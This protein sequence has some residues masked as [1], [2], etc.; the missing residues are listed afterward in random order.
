MIVKYSEVLPWWINNQEDKPNQSAFNEWIQLNMQQE[1][2]KLNMQGDYS[3]IT[4]LAKNPN[5]KY[6]SVEVN[7]KTYYYYVEN[8]NL[9]ATLTYTFNLN[10][11]TWSTYFMKVFFSINP[12]SEVFIKRCHNLTCDEKELTKTQEDSILDNIKPV[13]G[14]IDSWGES[15][16]KKISVGQE[17]YVF[18]KRDD[19][20]YKGVNESYPSLNVVALYQHPN[21]VNS[22]LVFPLPKINKGFNFKVYDKKTLTITSYGNWS[23]CYFDIN[24]NQTF[25]NNFIGVYTIPNWLIASEIYYELN[26]NGGKIIGSSIPHKANKYDEFPLYFKINNYINLNNKNELLSPKIIDYIPLFYGKD[27]IYSTDFN[28]VRFTN[29]QSMNPIYIDYNGSFIAYFKNILGSLDTYAKR[30]PG[31]LK[32]TVDK[33]QEYV[34]QN[35][36]RIN[37]GIQSTTLGIIQGAGM[38]GVGAASG[39]PFAIAGG[40]GG[41]IGSGTS[42]LNQTATIL[43]MKNSLIPKQKQSFIIDNM[44][45]FPEFSN[46]IMPQHLMIFKYELKN[47]VEY[48]NAIV[49]YGYEFNNLKK[50][51][52]AIINGNAS[53]HCFVSFRIDYYKKMFYKKYQSIPFRFQDEY[54]NLLNNGIRIWS[55]QNMEF[56]YA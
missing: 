35:Q 11:D 38:I 4:M 42:L 30:L 37:S 36:N 18:A 6:I 15:E 27:R 5:I 56:I 22:Y 21:Y 33:Y 53:N 52:D 49:L 51:K 29:K 26:I 43:D 55:T 19:L 10:I 40:F 16:F 14:N 3:K 31:P 9:I 46:K 25:M 28:S 2:I 39:N 1:N 13:I 34:A 32:S 7:N 20:Y 44:Y 12:D 23:E 8:M 24:Q 45:D 50:F 54:F 47:L 17:Q 48:N 41:L